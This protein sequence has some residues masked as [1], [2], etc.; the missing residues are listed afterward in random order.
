MKQL[1][2]LFLL[3]VISAHCTLRSRN[4]TNE[5]IPSLNLLLSDSLTIFN[6]K[7][8]ALGKPTLLIYFSPDCELCQD[9][10]KELLYKIDILSNTQIYLLTPM[11]FTELQDFNKKYN[12]KHYKNITIGYD[13]ENAFYN[14]FKVPNFPCTIIYDTKMNLIRIYKKPVS[15]EEIKNAIDNA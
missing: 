5:S 12:L 14:Y 1:P 4:S 3:L 10:I 11:P 8:V 2:V 9:E 6:T 7:H 13:F 15:P